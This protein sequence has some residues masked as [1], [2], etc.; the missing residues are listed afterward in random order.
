[1]LE[2]I[3]AKTLK[4][5][6]A[7]LSHVD[8]KTGDQLNALIE[9]LSDHKI[10]KRLA[11]KDSELCKAIP[12]ETLEKDPSGRKY[13]DILG[14]LQPTL[15]TT[16]L[17]VAE[18]AEPV[19]SLPPTIEGKMQVEMEDIPE[20]VPRQEFLNIFNQTVDNDLLNVANSIKKDIDLKDDDL[21]E[22]LS[23]GA[24]MG[25][26]MNLIGKFSSS[27]KERIDK[28]EIN[29]DKMQN[30]AMDLVEKM[31]STPEFNKVLETN[32]SLGMM[33]NAA[34]LMSGNN[35]NAES[36]GMD[37]P[38]LLQAMMVGNNGNTESTGMAM[39]SLDFLQAMMG[40]PPNL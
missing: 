28:G 12:K 6:I 14:M 20:D 16:S 35:E 7:D 4:E 29:V 21:H 10:T 3:I 15:K 9:G 11:N 19:A 22:M 36:M 31:K 17:P 27:V 40:G 32:P 2:G 26:M 33:M 1:M 25:K 34:G 37:M 8:A 13:L 24:D 30:Q 23:G 5:M 38:S 18:K 39:P